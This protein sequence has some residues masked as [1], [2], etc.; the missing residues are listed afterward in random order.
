MKSWVISICGF[1]GLVQGAVS[2]AALPPELRLGAPQ[3]VAVSAGIFDPFVDG[4]GREI[5]G[6]VRFA[7]RRFQFFPGILPEVVP[8]L[9]MAATGRGALY[10]YAGLRAELAAGRRWTFSPSVGAGLYK[11]SDAFDL[12]GPLE[13]RTGFELAWRLAS[14][15]RLGLC[16]YHLSNGGLFNRNP[17]SES[18]ILTYSAPLA[19]RR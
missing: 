5:G 17:G 9:G 4:S 12:G 19:R 16:L 6:E 14:G 18:L 2:L 11:K 10:T 1:V 13:F 15:S 8:T 7:P 3:E